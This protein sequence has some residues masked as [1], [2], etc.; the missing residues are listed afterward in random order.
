MLFRGVGDTYG[1]ASARN[2]T[3]LHS[4]GISTLPTGNSAGRAGGGNVAYL[5]LV[6]GTT[7][8]IPSTFDWISY[9]WDAIC[10]SL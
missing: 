9:T 6:V 2:G 4:M 7:V 5:Y 1:A 10:R 3:H 8:N